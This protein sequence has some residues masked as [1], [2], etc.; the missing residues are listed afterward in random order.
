[1]LDTISTTGGD[2]SVTAVARAAGV[3]RSFLYRHRDLLTELH[4]LQAAPVVMGNAVAVTAASLR[5]ELTNADKRIADLA[6]RNILLERKLSE[7]MGEQ[8]WRDSGLGAP[9]DIEQLQRKIVM[10]EQQVVE[11]TGQLRDRDQ[12]LDAAR[13]E[14]REMFTN[15]NKRT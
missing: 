1:M 4:R 14:N 13:A 9:T 6:A 10:L 8:A 5:V 15:M 2:P 11:L 7:A 3:D 12:E